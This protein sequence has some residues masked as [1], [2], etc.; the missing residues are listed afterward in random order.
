[1]AHVA[2]LI[3]LVALLGTAREA[4]AHAVLERANPAVGSAVRGS[5][6]ELMLHFSEELESAFSTIHVDN[7]KGERVDTGDAHVDA[8]DASVL[9]VA[10]PP[11]PPGRYH[12]IWRVVSVDTHVTEG[13]YAFDVLP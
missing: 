8:H 2:F 10:L 13:R 1:V 12:V 3:A 9:E 7:A 11:L 5:P 4:D 6:H